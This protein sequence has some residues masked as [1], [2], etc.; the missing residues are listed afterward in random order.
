MEN[1][2]GRHHR[3]VDTFSADHVRVKFRL[4]LVHLGYECLLSLIGIDV[5]VMHRKHARK[6]STT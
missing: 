6:L 3:R 1:D 4:G 2:R 5:R